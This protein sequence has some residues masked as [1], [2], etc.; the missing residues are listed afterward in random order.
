MYYLYHALTSLAAPTVPALLKRRLAKGKE[1]A[2]RL[3][4]R[5]GVAS[6]P[7]P[8]G[9]LLWIHAASVG[10]ANA[11]LPLVGAL[12]DE[13][14]QL[15]VLLTT[16][17]VTSAALMKKQLP[18]RALHQFAPVDTPD[19]VRSF[20]GHWRPD[21]ALF[22]DSELWPNLIVETRRRGTVMG[23]VNA[24][25]SERSFRRWRYASSFIRKL[26]SGFTLCFAQSEADGERLHALGI[27]AVTRVGN[28]K[29]DAPELACDE[30]E[31]DRLRREVGTRSVWVAA[32]THPGEE[33]Q[34]AAVHAAIGK[35]V[36]RP[37]TIVVPRHVVRGDAIMGELGGFSVARRSKREPVMAG[38]DIYLADTM[39]EL[40]LFYR[41]ASIAFVGGTLVAHGGQNPLEAAKL[42]CAVLAGPHMENFA[43]V[44][45]AMERDNAIVRVRDAAGLAQ[46]LKRLLP[47]GAARAQL[48]AKAR[49]HVQSGGGVLVA[50]TQELRP[51]FA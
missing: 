25:M 37:L 36:G 47:D 13:H 16:V 42:G 39:G 7:R 41:L 12:L 5:L 34:I 44:A 32:S 11:V 46:E 45:V 15:H 19:A 8:A 18:E 22:V 35:D 29:Y 49:T 38:T 1:D 10:E 20:L 48:A 17:T 24:R 30:A 6:A 33:A 50:I 4:E 51:Y 31:L 27:P 9:K 26:L 14:P 2:A 43:A 40:G 23:I 28:L 3:P 21:V